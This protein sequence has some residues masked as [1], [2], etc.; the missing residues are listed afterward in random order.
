LH[1]IKPILNNIIFLGICTK[2]NF[3]AWEYYVRRWRNG[4]DEASSS[5]VG[6]SSK[7]RDSN[8]W[9]GDLNKQEE[10]NPQRGENDNIIE[11]PN[12]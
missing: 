7:G 4:R 2:L 8:S 11:E 5:Q 10:L 12:R 9:E 1:H 3:E 6:H